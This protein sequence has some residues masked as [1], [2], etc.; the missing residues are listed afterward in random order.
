M[1]P[2]LMPL[3]VNVADGVTQDGA[4]PVAVS[5]MFVARNGKCARACCA[6]SRVTPKSNS[7]LPYDVASRPHRFSTSIVGMSSS[8]AEFG[9]EAP[10][11]SPPARIS[12][13]PG[14]AARVLVEHGRQ[15]GGP[16]DRDG[17]AVDGGR[18]RAE[19]T[20]E[21]VEP[22]DRDRLVGV[23]ALDHVK[24]DLALAVLRFGDAQHE[25]QG[26][27]EVDR[28]GRRPGPWRRRCRRPGRSLAC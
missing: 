28:A 4:L 11:L 14:S 12:P 18:R 20:V 2:T 5:T 26:R 17:L 16:A 21:V 7:W 3:T 15:L 25:G 8:S 27:C 22:D 23:A 24:E 9:G 10:T 1:T 6:S 13:G 19:L